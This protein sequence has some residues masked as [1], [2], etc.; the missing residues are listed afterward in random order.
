MTYSYI[1]RG[2]NL[3]GQSVQRSC[4][5]VHSSTEGEVGVGQSAAH[6]VTGV[7]ADVSTLMVTGQKINMCMCYSP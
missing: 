3:I 6:Q 4:Q 2:S 1:L 7:C 5:A